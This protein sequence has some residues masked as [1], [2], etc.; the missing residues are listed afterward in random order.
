[1]LILDIKYD[2]DFFTELINTD[3]NQSD[4]S[5]VCQNIEKYIDGLIQGLDIN[6]SFLLNVQIEEL[7]KTISNPEVFFNISGKKIIPIFKD[8]EVNLDSIL[9]FYDA[10]DK[11]ANPTII[12]RLIVDILYCTSNYIKLS[13]VTNQKLVLSPHRI[14]FIIKKIESN[15]SIFM[16]NIRLLEPCTHKIFLNVQ[17]FWK[18]MMI[19]YYNHYQKNEIKD[20]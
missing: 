9:E 12:C 20:L 11:Q 13:F 7:W 19:N 16:F 5:K 2:D 1:M 10:N 4:I 6:Y 17:K 15:K 8:K 18:N 14:T 3:F